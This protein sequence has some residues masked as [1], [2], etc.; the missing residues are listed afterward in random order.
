MR[1]LFFWAFMSLCLVDAASGAQQIEGLRISTP[2][3]ED[4]VSQS[5][6]AASTKDPQLGFDAVFPPVP[7]CLSKV[8]L[9]MYVQFLDLLSRLDEFKNMYGPFFASIEFYVDGTWCDP[10][11]S[12]SNGYPCYGDSLDSSLI[13]EEVHAVDRNGGGW[14]MQ[15]SFVDA[16]SRPRPNY[17]T[18]S[19]FLFITD[20]VLLNMGR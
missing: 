12:A 10:R 20:D 11:S 17:E 1:V 9:V 8:V 6:L 18:P 4:R 5:P 2:T 19:G 15:R 14:M 3:I 13:P 16:V 7:S